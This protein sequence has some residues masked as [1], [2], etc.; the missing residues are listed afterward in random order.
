MKGNWAESVSTL[1]PISIPAR[2]VQPPPLS[3]SP[4]GAA[5][6]VPFFLSQP[7][8][9]RAHSDTD[10][11]SLSPSSTL[12]ALHRC[13]TDLG[14]GWKHIRESDWFRSRWWVSIPCLLQDL[15]SPPNQGNLSLSS[16]SQSWLIQTI[17]PLPPVV[18][19][20]SSLS[21]AHKFDKVWFSLCK[22]CVR[23]FFLSC[24]TPKRCA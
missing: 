7:Q 23:E 18:R 2:S 14:A 9:R 20:V 12:L 19:F 11:F 10:V 24:T 15:G 13:Q 3:S 22:I 4:P 17:L 6:K 8:R 5:S 1:Q 21:S 16:S